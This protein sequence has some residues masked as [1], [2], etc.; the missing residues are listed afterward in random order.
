MRHAR[1]LALFEGPAAR[2]AAIVAVDT[3]GSCTTA[4]IHALLHDGATL[5]LGGLQRHALVVV[6]V[7]LAAR[8]GRSG[9]D[10]SLAAHLIEG[11]NGREREN[12]S[13]AR[14][15]EIFALKMTARQLQP[16]KQALVLMPTYVVGRINVTH[17]RSPRF[18]AVNKP[19]SHVSHLGDTS[20]LTGTPSR[21][22]F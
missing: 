1:L 4:S 5:L 13:K 3:V 11:T 19:K 16:Q 10:Q 6:D 14:Q 15:N 12:R 8:H 18:G 2:T 17:H 20:P 7:V 22:S 9:W 21:G